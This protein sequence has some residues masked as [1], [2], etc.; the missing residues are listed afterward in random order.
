M[1]TCRLD[2]QTD[3]G[4]PQS[5]R[6]LLP[7]SDDDD[8]FRL[9]S[10]SFRTRVAEEDAVQAELFPGTFPGAYFHSIVDMRT[11]DDEPPRFQDWACSECTYM[12]AG[13][14]LRVWNV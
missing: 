10:R 7:D 11:S 9:P 4:P 5:R 2:P 12:N 6:F 8:D 14:L 1:I 13:A 3:G